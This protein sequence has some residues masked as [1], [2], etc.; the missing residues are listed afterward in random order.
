MSFKKQNLQASQMGAGPYAANY[1]RAYDTHTEK[2][3][4]AAFASNPP[5]YADHGP[6]EY[7]GLGTDAGN[8]AYRNPTNR[9][10]DVAAHGDDGYLGLTMGP[11]EIQTGNA[12]SGGYT[13]R[14]GLGFTANQKNVVGVEPDLRRMGQRNMDWEHDQVGAHEVR[15]RETRYRRG[16]NVREDWATMKPVGKPDL[17]AHNGIEDSPYRI[18]DW[19]DTH[20]LTGEPGST[21]WRTNPNKFDNYD[22]FDSNTSYRTTGARYNNGTHYSMAVHQT[23]TPYH[24]QVDGGTPTRQLRNT[25]RLDPQPW[26]ATNTDGPANTPTYQTQTN[27]GAVSYGQSYRLT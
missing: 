12:P 20:S 24:S 3:S 17:S 19:P 6:Y 2:G 21:T 13:T 11:K 8:R 23:L 22:V 4:N 15:D 26:D 14:P 9:A 10:A 1:N 5:A 25:Y 16:L 27:V 7:A 18:H